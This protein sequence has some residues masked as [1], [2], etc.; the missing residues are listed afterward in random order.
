MAGKVFLA[1]SVTG[2]ESSN[3]SY[4]ELPLDSAQIK[5]GGSK[6]RDN[7]GRI[8]GNSDS[9]VMFGLRHFYSLAVCYDSNA[10]S[11]IGQDMRI[12]VSYEK[13]APGKAT[14]YPYNN[15][16]SREQANC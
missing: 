12:N 10:V 3:R 11:V 8:D 5:R 13:V 2:R 7:K 15:I 9:E 14:V 6:R 4:I 16:L 1:E